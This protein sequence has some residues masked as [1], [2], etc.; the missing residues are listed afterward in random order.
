MDEPGIIGITNDK[1]HNIRDYTGF[2]PNA[3]NTGIIRSE[4]IVAQFELKV[5]DVSDA[6]SY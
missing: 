2:D 3:M 4:M 6:V 1:A 5:Y